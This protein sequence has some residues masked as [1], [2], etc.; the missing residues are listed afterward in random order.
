MG[1]VFVRAERRGSG[2]GKQVTWAVTDAL[3][4]AGIRTIVLNVSQQNA[5]AIRLYEQLG[6]RRYCAFYEGIANSLMGANR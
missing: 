3:L 6:F 2:L 4:R 1:N 5:G